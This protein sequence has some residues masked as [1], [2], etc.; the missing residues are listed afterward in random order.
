MPVLDPRTTALVLIDLQLRRRGIQTMVLG[1]IA[2]NM[3]VESTARDAYEHIFPR[4]SRVVK[5][6][7]V[8]LQA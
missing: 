4:I 7:D 8:S 3:G 2:T 1:G 5:A 6:A